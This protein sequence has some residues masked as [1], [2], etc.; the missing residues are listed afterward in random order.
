MCG[1]AAAIG[2]VDQHIVDAVARMCE[3]QTHRGPDAS[4]CVRIDIDSDDG[5]AV[6]LAHRRLSIIDLAAHS[7]QPMRDDAT[8]NV[9]IYNGEV[10]NFRELRRE[11]ESDGVAFRT[12]G[13]TEVVLK[14]Y[15][16]WGEAAA[17][18]FR[19]MFALAIW[20]ARRSQLVLM[21]DRLGIKPL[22]IARIGNT[23]RPTVLIASELRALLDSGLIGRRLNPAALASYHW[24]GFVVGRESIID[25]VEL[26]PA[27]AVATIEPD[28]SISQHSYWS[29]AE[30]DTATTT[31]TTALAGELEQAV[32]QRL[33]SDVPLGVFLSGGIDSSAV[34][35]LAVRA[36]Q[37]PIQTFNIS[38]DETD[39]DESQHARAVAERIGT[40]HHELRLTQ[41]MFAGSLECALR[42]IDQPTFDAIN[43]YFVSRAVREAGL[44]VALAGTGGDELFG[45]YRS[46]VDLPRAQRWS[47]LIGSLPGFSQR[48]LADAIIRLKCGK[49]GTAPPQTRW[50]KLHDVLACHGDLVH[51]YQVSY[52]LFTRS[53]LAALTA[54][55]SSG[56]AFGLPPDIDDELHRAIDGVPQLSAIS[57]LE[58]AS[59]IGQRLLRDTD[60]ASMAVSLEV[61]VP[62]LDHR[63][64]EEAER[65]VPS[66]RY[67]P[68]GRKQLLRRLAMPELDQSMFDRPK[69]GFVLPI[70]RWSRLELRDQV[71]E[72]LSDAALC[73]SAG[74]DAIT[75]QRLWTAF[76]D[77]G[78]GLYWS[79]IWA[80]YVLLWWCR[81]YRV[82]L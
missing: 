58:L 3:A 80:V 76:Q 43:T 18:R 25:G 6:V 73:A 64:V 29:L 60:A 26:L 37:S 61:R 28:G 12:S 34:T 62:L 68:V 74:L 82:S 69:A 51:L 65:L 14:A 41:Q 77:G 9:L 66:V 16:R 59:F 13:D 1:L 67:D 52:G 48:T 46:F 19:G 47:R 42:S 21:R 45:G 57:R 81:Q 44:T 75:V 8:G 49:Q 20:D 39:F 7:N 50:G 54:R 53:F 17:Q 5:R 15:S 11:L 27:G 10:Y 38:F 35:S 24:H 79:R 32:A 36:S 2:S 72:T 30:L 71:S 33:I 55:E 56:A 78:T 40:E 70:E 63:V 4:G 22:Y 23:G 31:D